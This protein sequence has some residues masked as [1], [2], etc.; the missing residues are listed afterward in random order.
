ME[1]QS[2]HKPLKPAVWIRVCGETVAEWLDPIL[3]GMEEEGIPAELHD[4][5]EDVLETA[6][7][8]AARASP[9]EVGVA[10]DFGAQK[11]V[12][13]HRDLPQAQPILKLDSASFNGQGLRRLGCNAARLV[14]GDPLVFSNEAKRTGSEARENPGVSEELV[15]L[16]AAIVRHLIGKI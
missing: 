14:K 1:N 3:L 5:A 8:E 16:V 12:L 13:H 10:V 4:G 15:T 2:K 11:A 7:W 6:A 9:L